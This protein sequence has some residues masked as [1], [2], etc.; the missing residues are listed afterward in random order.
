M[1]LIIPSLCMQDTE[2]GRQS[3][4]TTLL[5]EVSERAIPKPTREEA[6]RIKQ[7]VRPPVIQ[8][9]PRLCFH[10]TPPDG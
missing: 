2:R 5:A 9:A 10:C 8:P 3:S 7:E 6:E 4:M 1:K